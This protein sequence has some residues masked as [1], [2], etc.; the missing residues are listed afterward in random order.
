MTLSSGTI[1]YGFTDD[2]GAAVTSDNIKRQWFQAHLVCAAEL[3]ELAKPGSAGRQAIP[4]FPGPDPDK[5]KVLDNV[6]AYIVKLGLPQETL[7]AYPHQL[8]G[9]MRQRVM[10]AMATFFQHS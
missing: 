1:E 6:S 8:S 10:I 5:R 9:G 7:D 2:H 3:D 4:R